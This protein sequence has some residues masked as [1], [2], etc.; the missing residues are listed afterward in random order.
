MVLR[1]CIIGWGVFICEIV[2]ISVCMDMCCMAGGSWAVSRWLFEVVWLRIGADVVLMVEKWGWIWCRFGIRCDC[3]WRGCWVMGLILR[4]R[5]CSIVTPGWDRCGEWY[6]CWR[7][8]VFPVWNRREALVI[9]V[10]LILIAALEAELVGQISCT[11]SKSR[12]L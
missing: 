7:C 10:L 1:S 11:F 8:Y 2:V 4:S 6:R 9:H 3:W 12:L 5:C